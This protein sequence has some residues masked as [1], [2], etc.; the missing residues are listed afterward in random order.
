MSYM[1]NGAT[2]FNQDIGSWSTSSVTD[3]SYMF[4]DATSFNQDIGSP[5]TS[6][7][8]DMSYMFNG[9]TAFN[10]DIRF[11]NVDSETTLT[12]MFNSATAF[13]SEYSIG[14]SLNSTFFNLKIIQDSNGKT[15]KLSYTDIDDVNAG[16]VITYNSEDYLVVSDG[17]NNGYGIKNYTYN[18]FYIYL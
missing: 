12:D 14:E 4:N 1:F 15:L 6:S 18:K 16:T 17:N 7:V 11:W 8:T 9:A 10:K 2:T 3:M 13:K 5:T